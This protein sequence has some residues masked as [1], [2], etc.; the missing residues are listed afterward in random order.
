MAENANVTVMMQVF[1][2]ELPMPGCGCGS[3]CGPSCGPES[4]DGATSAPTIEEQAADLEGRLACYYGD[5]VQVE[6][7]DVFSPRMEDF[8]MAQRAV[9]A[10]NVPLPVIAFDGQPRIAG[11]IS[12][13]MIS[14]ELEKRGLEVPGHLAG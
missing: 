5:G 2:T 9:F 13:E 4:E 12:I 6:Y 7:V 14:E 8:P 11:G 3:D 10:M 1:G